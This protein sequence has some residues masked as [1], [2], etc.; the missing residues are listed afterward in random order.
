MSE[1]VCPLALVRT[2][3]TPEWF[4]KIWFLSLLLLMYACMLVTIVVTSSHQHQL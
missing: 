4:V 2:Y 3:E 1:G